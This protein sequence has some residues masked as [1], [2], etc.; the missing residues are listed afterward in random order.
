VKK[1][2]VTILILKGLEFSTFA[3]I[4]RCLRG[5]IFSL[6][7]KSKCQYISTFFA[8][9]LFFAFVLNKKKLAT[10]YQQPVWMCWRFRIFHCVVTATVE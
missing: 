3:L 10:D 6:G 7:S 9:P 1:A 4:L 2:R 5:T 8:P